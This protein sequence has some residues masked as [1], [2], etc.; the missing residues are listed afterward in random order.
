MTE[1]FPIPFLA[2]HS[3]VDTPPIG[4]ISTPT[5]YHALYVNLD[6]HLNGHDFKYVVFL[7]HP[8]EDDLNALKNLEK[9][10]IKGNGG[11]QVDLKI[12]PIPEKYVM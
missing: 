2:E 3:P 6:F 1:E 8:L 4:M 12:S 10:I 7:P 9:L 5:A 11:N